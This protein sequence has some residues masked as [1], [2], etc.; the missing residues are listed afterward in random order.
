MYRK[1]TIILIYLLI[2]SSY[3]CR[4]STEEKPTE[5]CFTQNNFDLVYKFI[6]N[7]N[8]KTK[9][10]FLKYGDTKVYLSND[11]IITLKK[12]N[13]YSKIHRKKGIFSL[14]TYKTKNI[15]MKEEANRLFCDL[16]TKANK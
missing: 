3:S 10:K 13:N 8:L 6:E 2:Y 12:G 15:E 16:V 5:S 7:Q 14:S 11:K 1:I 4:K 9:S